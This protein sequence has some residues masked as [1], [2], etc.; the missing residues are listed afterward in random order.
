VGRA[1]G[2]LSTCRLLG[3]AEAL[4][5]FFQLRL[6]ACLGWLPEDLLP[7]L[8]HH[9]RHLPGGTFRAGLEA[10]DLSK[11]EEDAARARY[12]QQFVMSGNFSAPAVR[13]GPSGPRNRSQRPPK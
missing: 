4:C 1:W 13:S 5:G 3:A 10:R 8:D 9:A 11:L 7:R 2:V 6:G 12:V